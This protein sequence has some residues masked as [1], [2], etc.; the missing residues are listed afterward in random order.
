MTC[1]ILPHQLLWCP[2]NKKFHRNTCSSVDEAACRVVA[3][4]KNKVM[5]VICKKKFQRCSVH[6]TSV[7]GM[8]I[9]I[10]VH[11]ITFLR[12]KYYERNLKC[13]ATATESQ[14]AY[15]AFFFEW[16]CGLIVHLVILKDLWTRASSLKTVKM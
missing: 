14:V 9:F 5:L 10:K 11:R 16:F 15:S 12:K 3:L 8:P 7:L 13:S 4:F 2:F 1:S 6:Q